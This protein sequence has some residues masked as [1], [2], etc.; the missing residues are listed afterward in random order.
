MDVIEFLP[1]LELNRIPRAHESIIWAI[2]EEADSA[3]IIDLRNEES[4]TST[5]LPIIIDHEKYFDSLLENFDETC[6]VLI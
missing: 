5:D 6:C 2:K 4:N 3:P 1:I